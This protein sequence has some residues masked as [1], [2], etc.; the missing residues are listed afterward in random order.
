MIRIRILPLLAGALLFGF[1]ASALAQADAAKTTSDTD[2]TFMRQ[3]AGAGIAEVQMGQ[4]ALTKSDNDAVK[5]LAQRI[6]D[7]HAKANAQLKTLAGS[8]QV[9][10]PAQPA[11]DAQQEAA[12]LRA[13][14]GRAFDQAWA[15]AMVGD[16]QKAVKL[17][18]TESRAG[19]DDAL[20]QFASSTL[21]VLQ[22]HLQSAQHLMAVPA[23]RDQ[24]MEHAMSMDP[25]PA[26]PSPTK[27]AASADTPLNAPPSSLPA[28]SSHSLPPGR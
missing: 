15:K 23:A 12:R 26:P 14:D 2:R 18:R 19:G 13:L 27:P 16:H 10:L 7:D 22:A 4:L 3:A 8:R 21:P 28:A 20:R 1:A 24:A 25:T 11:A 17:F 5:A 6:V 9:S